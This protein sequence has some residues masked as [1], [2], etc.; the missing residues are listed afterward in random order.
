M[1][2]VLCI[3]P[4]NQCIFLLLWFRQRK[5]STIAM[6]VAYV[7]EQKKNNFDRYISKQ[8]SDPVSTQ[9]NQGWWQGKIFPLCEVWYALLEPI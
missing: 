7:G 3:N 2:Y 9:F 1:S 8:S 5:G 6:I 4:T